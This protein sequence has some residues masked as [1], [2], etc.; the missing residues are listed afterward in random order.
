[1]EEETG[2]IVLDKILTSTHSLQEPNRLLGRIVFPVLQRKTTQLA[3]MMCYNLK[4]TI[5]Y[6]CT[7]LI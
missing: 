4:P 6:A 2:G 1:M 3:E 7:S 5:G